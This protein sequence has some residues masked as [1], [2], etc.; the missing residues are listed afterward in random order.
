MLLVVVALVVVAVLG[1]WPVAALW[2]DSGVAGESDAGPTCPVVRMDAPPCPP[3][4]VGVWLLATRDDWPGIFS[5][6]HTGQD[7][8]IHMGLP[9][10]HY[11]VRVLWSR[12]FSN[13]QL[14][15]LET[16]KQDATFGPHSFAK[17]TVGFDTGIR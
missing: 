9:P 11:T 14:P 7:G 2:Q 12:W 8:R 4:H 6:S 1:P 17:L 13:S 10:R 16:P 5:I 15:I 3:S